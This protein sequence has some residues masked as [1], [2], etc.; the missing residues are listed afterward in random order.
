MQQ[1]FNSINTKINE[2]HSHHMITDNDILTLFTN[3]ELRVL[4]IALTHTLSTFD[5]E[6]L[7]WTDIEKNPELKDF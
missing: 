1:A 2:K 6:R 4:R 5:V 3:V 7:G